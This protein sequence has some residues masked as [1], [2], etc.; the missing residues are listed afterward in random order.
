MRNTVIIISNYFN[1]SRAFAPRRMKIKKIRHEEG[2]LIEPY[3]HVAQR[4]KIVLS[5][6][7]FQFNFT[8]NGAFFFFRPFNETINYYSC[9][10]ACN[11]GKGGVWAGIWNNST[12]S[13]LE[14]WWC[15]MPCVAVAAAASVAEV[16]QIIITRRRRWQAALWCFDTTTHTDTIWFQSLPLISN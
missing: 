1:P 9:A 16:G 3:I 4:R 6:Q 12:R 14:L 7:K 15:N 8:F 10:K 5:L 13:R 2:V 11:G